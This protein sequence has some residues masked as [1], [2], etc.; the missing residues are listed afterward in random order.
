MIYEVIHGERVI[1]RLQG[2]DDVIDNF[3]A[4]PSLLINL[5]TFHKRVDN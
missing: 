3:S 1:Y 5:L 2:K 4:P